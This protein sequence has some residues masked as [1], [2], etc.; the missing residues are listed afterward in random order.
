LKENK[1]SKMNV[2]SV[3]SS[4]NDSSTASLLQLSNIDKTGHI[5]DKSCANIL[6]AL[7][8]RADK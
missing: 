7:S 6:Q 4:S 1:K 5:H 2:F 3:S 8:C